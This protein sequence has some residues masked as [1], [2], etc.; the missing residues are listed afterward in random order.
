MSHE[1]HPWQQALFDALASGK[2]F[3]LPSGRVGRGSEFRHLQKLTMMRAARAG[4]K[5]VQVRKGEDGQLEYDEI[6]SGMPYD[7]L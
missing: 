2:K 6:T 7:E 4:Y 3:I 5:V 1:L